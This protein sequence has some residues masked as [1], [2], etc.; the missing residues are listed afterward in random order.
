MKRIILSIA[1]ILAMC[2][3]TLTSFAASTE[4]RSDFKNSESLG[5]IHKRLADGFKLLRQQV[6]KSPDGFI[7]YPYSD[8]CRFLFTALGLGCLLHG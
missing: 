4:N 3:M 5:R 2:N 1:L 6:V 8:T 7:K